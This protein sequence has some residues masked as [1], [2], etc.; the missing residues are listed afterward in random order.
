[1][2]DF[3]VYTVTAL[4]VLLSL[5][6]MLFIYLGKS[7]A[8][9]DEKPQTIKYGKLEVTT[10]SVMGLIT[11]SLVTAVL[12]LC[13]Q[14]YLILEGKTQPIVKT[15][16]IEAVKIGQ[17]DGEEMCGLLKGIYKL[18]FNYVF[19]KE[20]GT[21]IT[22]KKGIW[23]ANTCE[24]K[25]KGGFVLKGEDSTDFEIK[26]LINNTYLPVAKGTFYYPSEVLIDEKGRPTSRIF[27]I[28]RESRNLKI[29]EHV[30]EKHDLNKNRSFIEAEIKRALE[31]RDRKHDGMTTSYCAPAMGKMGERDTL[32]FI[33]KDYTR[34]MVKSF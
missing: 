13:L 23:K 7:I 16:P 8:G 26:I 25:Q 9:T 28:A 2:N 21:E 33:C 15:L 10:N 34:V 30:L 17:A 18:H 1:M 22:A 5:F 12:P 29:D 3:V 11:A 24:P 19:S 27:E 4:G 20:D 31:I 6:S 32:A 14:F